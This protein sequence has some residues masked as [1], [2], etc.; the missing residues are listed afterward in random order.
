E[1]DSDH[2][3]QKKAWHPL[4]PE[5]QITLQVNDSCSPPYFQCGK[6]WATQQGQTW[7]FHENRPWIPA[8]PFSP[9]PELA[10]KSK[11]LLDHIKLL[12]NKLNYAFLWLFGT[13]CGAPDPYTYTKLST[14]GKLHD[15]PDNEPFFESKEKLEN[16]T[17]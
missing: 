7:L 15:F 10:P 4:G 11:M 3:Y 13:Q 16:V 5:L 12:L 9:G 8:A 17:S 14:L 6:L 1:C 2:R